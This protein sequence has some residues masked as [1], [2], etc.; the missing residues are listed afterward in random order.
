MLSKVLGIGLRRITITR[1]NEP[2]MIE[3]HLSEEEYK[4]L[5]GQ[6]IE[7]YNQDATQS[8]K[9]DTCGKPFVPFQSAMYVSGKMHHSLCYD[10]HIK[11]A[12]KGGKNDFISDKEKPTFGQATS[13]EPP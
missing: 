11:E 12:A 7:D 2:F 6:V 5:Q 1:Y 4:E 3:I 8:I 13:Q 9:C 10:Y